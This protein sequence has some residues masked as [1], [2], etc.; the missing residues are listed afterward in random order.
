VVTCIEYLPWASLVAD[1]IVESSERL[2]SEI[3]T[4]ASGVELLLPLS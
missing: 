3:A 1:A 4:P 2:L